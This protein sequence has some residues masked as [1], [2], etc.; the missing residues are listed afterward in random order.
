MLNQNF[1]Q[2]K[3]HNIKN[4]YVNFKLK[5]YEISKIKINILK[6]NYIQYLLLKN[7]NLKKL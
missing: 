7:K 6:I 3:L 1:F 4:Y 2:I 5:Y